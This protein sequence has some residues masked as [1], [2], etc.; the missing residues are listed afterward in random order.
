MTK[1]EAQ[2]QEQRRINAVVAEAMRDARGEMNAVV[3]TSR[4]RSCSALVYETPSFYILQSYRTIIA[5]ID[6]ASGR[7][8][9]GLRTV[10]GYTATSAQHVSKFAHDYTTWSAE[11]YTSR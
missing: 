9:D 6:K 5:V 11:R 4:L 1:K 2:A 10:Y 8:F 7:L 3:R